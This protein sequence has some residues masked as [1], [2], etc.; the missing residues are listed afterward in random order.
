MLHLPLPIVLVSHWI[1]DLPL[2]DQV[3]KSDW[4]NEANPV[5]QFSA[6]GCFQDDDETGLVP[7]PEVPPA[8]LI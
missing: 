2:G 7:M 4:V 6:G 8:L 5:G 3:I 1:V